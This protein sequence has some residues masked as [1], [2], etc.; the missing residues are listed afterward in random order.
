MGASLTAILLVI[1]TASLTAILLVILAAALTTTL[2]AALAAIGLVILAAA[3]TASL[4]ALA[5][6]LLVILIGFI[7]IQLLLQFL[8]HFVDIVFQLIG[9]L[10]MTVIAA[11]RFTGAFVLCQNHPGRLQLRNSSLK[12]LIVGAVQRL[13][14]NLMTH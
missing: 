7:L 3:L 13:K 11:D 6:V 8:E 9:I 12:R 2:A 4:A 14:I 10:V 1:L 5:A